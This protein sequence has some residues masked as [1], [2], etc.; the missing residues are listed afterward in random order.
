MSKL[1]PFLLFIIPFFS[2]AQ[3]DWILK[4]D[5]NNIKIYTRSIVN[6]KLDE[7]KAITIID[8][9]IENVVKELVTAP[10]YNKEYKSG[11]SY[12]VKKQNDNQHVFYAHK[13]LPW[14]LKDRDL[15]TLLTIEKISKSKYKLKLESLPEIINQKEK[16]IRIK[17]L[18]GF[19]LL[20]EKNNSTKVIQQLFINPE[21]TLPAFVTNS[22]LINGPFKTFSELR[23]NLKNS[24][25]EILS[26]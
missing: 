24:K 18:K 2:N 7:Y 6:E 20:E 12:Y 21:G 22:L 17:E 13:D 5:D 10:K 8:T 14:P 3:T 26:K 19:W 9:Q 1:F 11:I 15:V 16:T 4:K 25:M 23:S